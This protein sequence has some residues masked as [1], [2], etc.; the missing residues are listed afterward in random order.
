[1]S[2]TVQFVRNDLSRTRI[3]DQ[4]DAPLGD[5]QVSGHDGLPFSA[6]PSEHSDYAAGPEGLRIPDGPPGFPG[7]SGH[8]GVRGRHP[9]PPDRVGEPLG[10]KASRRSGLRCRLRVSR[11]QRPIPAGH[12]RRGPCPEAL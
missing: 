6:K 10:I 9:A 7:G 1:M 12:A 5:G 3:A 8:P 4:A 11:R 2:Q